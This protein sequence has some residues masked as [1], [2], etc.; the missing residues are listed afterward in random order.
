MFCLDKVN[1]P[2]FI[3][4]YCDYPQ[5]NISEQSNTISYLIGHKKSYK[6]PLWITKFLT[7]PIDFFEFILKKDLKIN[8]MR[9]EKFTVPTYFIA[10]RIR[11]RGYKQK[12]TIIDSFRR[13]NTW[14]TSN[15]ISLLRKLWI[16]KASKL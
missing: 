14:I 8:S 15:N 9:V 5:K 2:L 7:I 10:D 12:T 1:D 4:N 3:Y 6:I 13:T 11:E 16:K